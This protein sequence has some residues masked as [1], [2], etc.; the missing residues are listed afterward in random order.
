MDLIFWYKFSILQEVDLFVKGKIKVT[1]SSFGFDSFSFDLL[2]V[3][4]PPLK[5]LL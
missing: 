3:E 2:K 4:K 1:F 5:I